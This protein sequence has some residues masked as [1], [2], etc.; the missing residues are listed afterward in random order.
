MKDMMKLSYVLLG[1]LLLFLAGCSDDDDHQIEYYYDWRQGPDDYYI[2]GLYNWHE[3]TEPSAETTAAFIVEQPPI[4]DY[5]PYNRDY[6]FGS[7]DGRLFFNTTDLP[8]E[9]LNASFCPI[10]VKEYRRAKPRGVHSADFAHYDCV[11]EPY[12]DATD[13]LVNIHGKLYD[14]GTGKKEVVY[15]EDGQQCLAILM[16]LDRFLA[17]EEGQDV[18]ISG[19]LYRYTGYSYVDYKRKNHIWLTDFKI[20]K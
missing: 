15:E 8:E 16:N 4:V 12:Y 2:I 13:S 19:R 10:Q 3:H 7:I 6:P 17:T 1:T 18:V 5:D 14:S 20:E 11:V 9:Y